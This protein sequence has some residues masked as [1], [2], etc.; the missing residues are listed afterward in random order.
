MCSLM[1]LA[2]QKKLRLKTGQMILAD[3][4]SHQIVVRI[5]N[6]SQHLLAGRGIILHS[7]A[8]RMPIVSAISSQASGRV[9]RRV[10]VQGWF[11][12]IAYAPSCVLMH[13]L[14]KSTCA[15]VSIWVTTGLL[16]KGG[17]TGPFG[18]LV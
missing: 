15:T 16:F 10:G 18:I 9:R 7:P 2:R 4:T 14:F 1:S 3:L 12:V 11:M 5:D 13:F 17:H 6:S 8:N